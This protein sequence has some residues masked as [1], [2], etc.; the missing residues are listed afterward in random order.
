[1]SEEE[2]RDMDKSFLQLLSKLVDNPLF[3]LAKIQ[4]L[5]IKDI[6]NA[7]GERLVK[8]RNI[9]DKEELVLLL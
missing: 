5:A 4:L 1:L 6:F 9:E 7:I 8:W 2:A 3:F